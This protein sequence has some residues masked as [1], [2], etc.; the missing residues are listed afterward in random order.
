MFG[1]ELLAWA[2]FVA[3]FLLI[4]LTFGLVFRS[5]LAGTQPSKLFG[6]RAF[7]YLRTGVG[8]LLCT[9]YYM[10]KF[11]HWSYKYHSKLNQSSSIGNWLVHT[12]LFE[13]AWTIV[14]TGRANWWWSSWICTWTVLFTAIVWSESGRRGIKYPYAY[15]LLGQLVAMSVA[16]ALFLTAISLHPR[17]YSSSRSMPVFI[18]LPL[19]LAFIPIYQLPRYV[20]TDKFM[21]S[22]LWLHGALLLPLTSSSTSSIAQNAKAKIPFSLF[23][24]MLL[25]TG[26]SIHYPATKLLL[27][28]LPKGQSLF[29]K[30]YQTAFAHPAQSSIS[31]DVIWVG[32]ILFSWFLL[33]GPLVFRITKITATGVAAGVAIAG[34]TGINWGLIASVIPILVL[35]GLGLSVI[36]LQKIRAKNLIRRKELLDKFG[37]PENSVIPGTTNAA[38]SMSGDKI[39]VGFWHPY[40]NASGGGERVLWSAVR[41][42]QKTEKNALVLVYSGDYPAASK[43]DILGR[44]KDR[45]SIEIDASRLHFVPLPSRFLVSGNY[46]KRFTLLNQSLGSIYLVYEGLCGKDGLWGDVFIDSMGHG[47]TFPTVRFLTGPQTVIGAYIHYPTVSTDMVK[48]VRARSEGVENAGASK[49]WIKTQIKLIYYQIFTNLYSISLLFPEHIMTNSSWTQAHVQSLLAKARKSF[50]AS[51]L[52]KDEM[53]IQKREERG[54]IKKEDR[55]RC[56]VVYP[57]CDTKEF[58]KLGSLD[59]RKSEIV[60]LAQFRPEK[61]HSKQLYALAA[62]FE[63]YPQYKTGAQSVKLIMMGGSRDAGDEARVDALRALAKKLDLH[64]H[65]EI[66][67]NAP[68]PGVVQ[69]LGEA[70]I[71]LNTMQDEHFGINVVEFMA[72]GLIPIVHASAGPLMD[73]V[74]PFK[75]QKTG[76]HATDAESFAE[77]IHEALRLSS[78]QSLTMRKAAREAAVQKF[79]EKEF[80]KHWQDGWIRL[81]SLAEKKRREQ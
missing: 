46:W 78:K 10:I 21:N 49:S 55:A 25:A 23:Y 20:N 44:A 54:E 52:L 35:L 5:I 40:C 71:G 11:L 56:E 39:V 50:W 19:L 74:V 30:L 34:L 72:A 2:I 6:G 47:F 22:L 18:A 7:F 38:P 41:H 36:G 70:S 64:G 68:Y 1:Q 12:P 31:L 45:F 48:R 27:Q 69:R 77:A 42:L 32:I 9:W 67:V 51:V 75:G 81:K 3:Y 66:V 65:V 80:E 63:R 28:S 61:E 59:K 17:K 16:T 8:A 62:L 60:S 4:L 15:M 37:M 33:S 53:T 76:F 24:Q 57:P 73:I 13:Q 14:C 79:S 29:V 26:I 58:V 43:E